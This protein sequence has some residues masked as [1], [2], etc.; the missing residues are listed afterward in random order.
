[1]NM[2]DVKKQKTLH[3]VL[4]E[5][6]GSGKRV[7]LMS[8]PMSILAEGFIAFVGNG[9]VAIKHQEKEEADEF[10]LESQII[11]I[12]ILGEYRQM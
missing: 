7:R 9:M 4:V 11:K 5:L 8:S 1:M 2:A 10:V 6:V 12:Q 3:D